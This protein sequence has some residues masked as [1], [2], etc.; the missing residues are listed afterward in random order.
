M[1]QVMIFIDSLEFYTVLSIQQE[2]ITLF[3]FCPVAYF[4]H[5]EKLKEHFPLWFKSVTFWSGS[6]LSGYIQENWTACSGLGFRCGA[7]T[8]SFG[9]K[10]EVLTLGPVP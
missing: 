3:I 4:S 9:G 5:W 8:W 1:G 2:P 10:R 6:V 7:N